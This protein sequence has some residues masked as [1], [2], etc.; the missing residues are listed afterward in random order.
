VA[1][2]FTPGPVE[3]YREALE[4][5]VKPVLSHRSPGFRELIQGLAEKLS[6]VANH[7]GGVAILAGSGTLA[8]E[9]MIYSLVSPG[10]GVLVIS[11]GVFG[12]RLAES[13]SRRG[14]RVYR[15][16]L[17][18]GLPLD[19]G[20][21]E[22][23][24]RRNRVSWIAAAHV[25]TSYGHRLSELRELSK[26]ASSLGAPLL[27]DAVS[28]FAGEELDS[29]GWGVGAIASCSQKALG[30]LPGVSFVL[31][32]DYLVERARKVSHSAPPPRYL[33][34]ATYI[35]HVER[36][37]TPYTPAV[38]LLHAL[39]GAVER[40]LRVG[41]AR[42]IEIHRE[43]AETLYR[44]LESELL[45]P[46]IGSPSYRA[47]TVAV[48]KVMDDRVSATQIVERLAERGYIVAKGI[49]AD[50]DRLVRIGTMGN[51]SPEDLEELASAVLEVVEDL[52]RAG[53]GGD[54]RG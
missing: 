26:I 4:G 37:S 29:S 3:P 17:D 6:R 11:Y 21:V 47:N 48:F 38:N 19:L 2:L 13:A 42:N 40:V 52:R 15:Y 45:S 24:V 46:L 10:D 33:D 53:A 43:R 16:A 1:R 50:G 44:S 30:A 20:A 22:D 54:P 31:V 8:T 41:V 36:G 7:R 23:I 18:P 12:D 51:I 25:E 28:S 32:A 39:E 5:L 27:L 49:G 9:A 34:L 35:E 14:A